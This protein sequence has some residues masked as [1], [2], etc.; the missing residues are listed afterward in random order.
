MRQI[1]FFQVLIVLL[2]IIIFFPFV[3]FIALILIIIFLAVNRRALIDIFRA[4]RMFS[5]VKKSNQQ[6]FKDQKTEKTNE[7][8][9][10]I[11]D[12]EEI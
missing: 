2:L 4:F 3:L 7:K 12:V 1:N 11:I 8:S 5:K 9:S 6:A 10:R